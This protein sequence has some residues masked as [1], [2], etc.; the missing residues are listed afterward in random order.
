MPTYNDINQA[1][2]INCGR[3][4]LET[5]RLEVLNDLDPT[6]AGCGIHC[7]AWTT[8]T[9]LVVTF[10]DSNGEIHRQEIQKKVENLDR[11][12]TLKEMI[13]K[14]KEITP[15]TVGDMKKALEN[16]PDDTQIVIGCSCSDWFNLSKDYELPNE[17]AGYMALTF[18]TRNDFDARQF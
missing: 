12:K 2:C 6:C 15:F 8:G 18:F 17:E 1:T 3:V 11:E 16:L 7:L 10:E 13:Q 14:I 5:D 4:T 9:G